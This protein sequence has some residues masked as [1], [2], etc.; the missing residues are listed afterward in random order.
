MDTPAFWDNLDRYGTRPCLI[1]HGTVHSY[2]AIERGVRGFAG[3]LRVG[4]KSLAI[5]SAKPEIQTIVTYLALLRAGYAICLADATTA[6]GEI[7][8]LVAAYQPYLV[9]GFAP[10]LALEGYRI[11]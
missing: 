3:Q 6:Q 10:D 8:S 11:Q 9:I 2:E 7:R 5:L 4:E 1:E